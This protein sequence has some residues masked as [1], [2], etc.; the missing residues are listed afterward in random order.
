M[1]AIVAHS[2]PAANTYPT[3]EIDIHKIETG[4]GW[5]I[6]KEGE[7]GESPEEAELEFIDDLRERGS[8]GPGL[9]GSDLVISYCGGRVDVEAS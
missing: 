2:L 5:L 9:L 3:L 6:R 4:R 1:T 7:P 8:W